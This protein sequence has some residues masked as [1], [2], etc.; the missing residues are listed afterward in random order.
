MTTAEIVELQEKVAQVEQKLVVSGRLIESV[1]NAIE[2]I[3][4]ARKCEAD[5]K[6]IQ[7]LKGETPKEGN[8]HG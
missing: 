5:I 8:Q 4:S 2:Q 6:G 1:M 7:L 3:S